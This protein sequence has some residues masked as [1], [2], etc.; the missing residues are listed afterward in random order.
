MTLSRSSSKRKKLPGEAS[1]ET[2]PARSHERWKIRSR[3]AW[4][5]SSEVKYS[6]E[7]VCW[8]KAVRGFMVERDFSTGVAERPKTLI[9]PALFSRPPPPPPQEKREKG[10]KGRKGQQGQQGRTAE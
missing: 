3:S 2:W 10:K 6:P 1:W 7:R 9:T 5:I 8:P 4:K